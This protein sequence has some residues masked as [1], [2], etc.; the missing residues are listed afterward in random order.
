VTRLQRKRGA[1]QWRR[2]HDIGSGCRDGVEFR[3]RRQ[4]KKSEPPPFAFLRSQCGVMKQNN[5]VFA[6]VVLTSKR[7]H[8]SNE[9]TTDLSAA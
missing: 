4:R 7:L 6:A 2:R 9:M 5:T 8:A 1:K 3:E